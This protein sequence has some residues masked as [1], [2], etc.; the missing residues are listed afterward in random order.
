MDTPK[1]IRRNQKAKALE[2]LGNAKNIRSYTLLNGFTGKP[3]DPID[4]KGE[5]WLVKGWERMDFARLEQT[6]DNKF[7]LSIHSNCWY[8]FTN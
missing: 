7:R 1:L 6:A 3:Y 2:I 8:E 4:Y 5:N